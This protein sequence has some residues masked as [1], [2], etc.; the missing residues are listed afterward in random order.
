MSFT[1]DANEGFAFQITY[2][3]TSTNGTTTYNNEF[4]LTM[5]DVNM[6]L[7][8]QS[9]ANNPEYVTTNNTATIPG[10]SPHGGTIYIHIYRY[11]GFGTYDLEFWTWSTSSTGGGGNGSG[12]QQ[13]CNPCNGGG[14]IGSGNVIPDILGAK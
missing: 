10:V 7:I 1:L 11:D 8:D 13:V 3:T 9:I 5:F 12:G 6:N 14:V 4:D 2:P